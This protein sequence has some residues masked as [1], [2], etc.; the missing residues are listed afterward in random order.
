MIQRDERHCGGLCVCPD[1]AVCRIRHRRGMCDRCNRLGRLDGPTRSKTAGQ[2]EIKDAAVPHRTVDPASCPFLR[3][4]RRGLLHIRGKR[5]TGWQVP[6][7]IEWSSLDRQ[8]GEDMSERP[9]FYRV[10]FFLSG[11]DPFGYVLL[12]NDREVFL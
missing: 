4:L 9:C 2:G 1:H 5:R 12:A 6:L 3:W 7:W 10:C 8:G 11:P